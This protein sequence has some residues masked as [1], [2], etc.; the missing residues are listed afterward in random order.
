LSA[1]RLSIDAAAAARRGLQNEVQ[2]RLKGILGG[3]FEKK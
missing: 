2:R 3:L 1:P